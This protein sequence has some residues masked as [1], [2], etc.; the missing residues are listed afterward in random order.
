M[1]FDYRRTYFNSPSL[2]LGQHLKAAVIRMRNFLRIWVVF[3]N[4]VAS[5]NSYSIGAETISS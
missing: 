1:K 3:N 4:A 2:F 5:N